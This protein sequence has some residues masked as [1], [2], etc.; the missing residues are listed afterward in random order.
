MLPSQTLPALLAFPPFFQPISL[1]KAPFFRLLVLRSGA[2]FLWLLACFSG[3]PIFDGR[4]DRLARRIAASVV[5]LSPVSFS[6]SIAIFRRFS[7]LESPDSRSLFG[8]NSSVIL[9]YKILPKSTF[10]TSALF[11][12]LSN[13]V[14]MLEEAWYCCLLKAKHAK[15][16]YVTKEEYLLTF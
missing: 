4:F 9:D 16:G 2:L 12:N 11:C 10:L 6:S 3:A 7:L 1:S 5:R 13:L 15:L 8:L 14:L